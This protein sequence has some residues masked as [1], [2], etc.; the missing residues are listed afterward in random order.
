MQPR[1]AGRSGRRPF[2]LLEHPRFRA[3]YDF[4]LLRCESGEVD[5]ELGKWWEAF[6]RASSSER[7]AMLLNDESQKKRR[8]SQGPPQSRG[9]R[10]GKQ[11]VVQPQICGN[12]PWRVPDP[13]IMPFLEPLSRWAAIWMIPASQVRRGI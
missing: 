12:N 1:F 2:R 7:E 3:A 11:R 9:W 6:Q 4:M 10:Y 13:R 8:R 5:M